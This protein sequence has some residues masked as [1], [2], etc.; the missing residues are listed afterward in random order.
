MST[1]EIIS[2]IPEGAELVPVD[3]LTT[4]EVPEEVPEISGIT[5]YVFTNRFLNSGGFEKVELEEAVLKGE[6]PFEYAELASSIAA[7]GDITPMVKK[8]AVEIWI[9]DDHPNAGSETDYIWIY[10][11]RTKKLKFWGQEK[12]GGGRHFPKGGHLQL[13]LNLNKDFM[14]TVPSDDWDDITLVNPSGD[15]IRIDRVQI[16]HSEETILDWN[17]CG[18]WLDGSITERYG[19]LGLARKIMETKLAE[20]GDFWH[21]QLFWAA[22]E[23]GKTDYTKY[24]TGPVW[25]S[26]FA[27]WCLRKVLWDTPVGSFGSSAMENFFRHRGRM[28]TKEQ[29]LDGTYELTPGDYLR[30]P[31]HSALFVKYLGSPNNPNTEIRSIDG[32]V[33]STVGMRRRQID[34]LVSVGCTR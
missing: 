23:I 1:I 31:N 5:G 25:C 12:P 13:D 30:F 8:N 6:K 27:S 32:N 33:S 2:H 16:I 15:G 29:L 26:E 17:P 7:D 9:D 3:H 20:I 19:K 11:G 28:F 18:H 21:P 24:G 22:L 10:F 14:E 34:R 4:I